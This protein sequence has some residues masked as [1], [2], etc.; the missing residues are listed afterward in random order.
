M[1]KPSDDWT[2][3][4]LLCMFGMLSKG[5]KNKKDRCSSVFCITAL[6][7]S[8]IELIHDKDLSDKTCPCMEEAPQQEHQQADGEWAGLW[9]V[10]HLHSHPVRTSLLCY[11]QPRL[12]DWQVWELDVDWLLHC[13]WQVG[14]IR[15]RCRLHC[16]VIHS[17]AG[18][19]VSREQIPGVFLSL[20]LLEPS[21]SLHPGMD[22][23]VA[24]G[25]WVHR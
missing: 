4:I 3:T 6:P 20:G 10:P 21:A 17:Q 14:K 9:Q 5:E 11:S 1:I 18:P 19:A 7:F 13:R 8:L 12:S 15:V 22:G 16:S 24:M 23:A 2:F 25:F